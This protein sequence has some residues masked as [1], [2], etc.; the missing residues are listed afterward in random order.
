MQGGGPI[1]GAI[2]G[3]A[4]PAAGLT[5]VLAAAAATVALPG[6]IGSRVRSLRRDEVGDRAAVAPDVPRVG[7]GSTREE[8]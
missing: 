4:L 2:G 8:A 3:V 5:A 7:G 1:G 6:A